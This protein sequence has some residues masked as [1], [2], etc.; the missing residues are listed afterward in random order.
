MLYVSR[1][2]HQLMLYVNSHPELGIVRIPEYLHYT[3]MEKYANLISWEKK[4]YYTYETVLMDY[5]KPQF[6]RYVKDKDTALNFEEIFK[7]DLEYMYP[8]EIMLNCTSSF[9]ILNI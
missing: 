9:E 4:N 6:I 3:E 2:K 8:G 5:V 7:T 1:D